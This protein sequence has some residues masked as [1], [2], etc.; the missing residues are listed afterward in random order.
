MG[1]NPVPAFKAGAKFKKMR[2]SM[3]QCL[4]EILAGASLCGYGFAERAVFY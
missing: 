3:A 4:S 1:F 2:H